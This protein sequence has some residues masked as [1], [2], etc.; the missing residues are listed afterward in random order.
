MRDYI[1]RRLLALIPTM[2]GITLITFLLINL[3]PGGPIEQKIQQLRFSNGGEAKAGAGFVSQEVLDSLKKQYGLDRPLL[4]RY[5]IWIKRICT[6]DFGDSFSF[7]EPVMTVIA[8]KL[9]VSLQFG[10]I[11]FFLT[12]L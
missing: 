8:R 12:Y 7:E 4:V 1:I 9:P 6:L 5:G 2:F 10:I 3:A 11:S